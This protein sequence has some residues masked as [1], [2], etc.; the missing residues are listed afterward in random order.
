MYISAQDHLTIVGGSPTEVFR[1]WRG[2]LS[3]HWFENWMWAMMTVILVPQWMLVLR[4]WLEIV[5]GLALNL[6]YHYG[7]NRLEFHLNFAG[8]VGGEG[9]TMEGRKLLLLV[10]EILP[11]WSLKTGQ[12]IG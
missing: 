10:L 12:E 2:V 11:M 3:L 7:T 4:G 9:G 6:R 8:Y 5:V 1:W